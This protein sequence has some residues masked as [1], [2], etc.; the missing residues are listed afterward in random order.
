[1]PAHD[2]GRGDRE[3]LRPPATVHQPGQRRKPE[4]VAVI[5]PQA[6]G[7]LTAQH[8][9]LVAQHEQLGVLGQIRPDEHRQQAEQ[10]PHQAVDERQNHPEMVPA[11][12]LIPQQNPNS[13]RETEFP[14]GTRS[15]RPRR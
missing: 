12:L 9:V 14:S 6:A 11:T 2:R 8:L 1:M 4:P 10:A 3:D 13:H 15:I 7:Q 5:P